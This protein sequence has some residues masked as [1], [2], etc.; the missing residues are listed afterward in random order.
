MRIVEKNLNAAVVLQRNDYQSLEASLK[1]KHRESL[2][3]RCGTRR[4]TTRCA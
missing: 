2:R 1:D 4:D 3:R